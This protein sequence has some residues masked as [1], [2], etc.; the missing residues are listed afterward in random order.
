MAPRTDIF[1]LGRLALSSGEGRSL[2]LDVGIDPLQLAGQSYGTARAVHARLDVSRTMHGYALRLRYEVSLEGP[3]MRC[4]EEA[5]PAI[6]VDA[7]EI[8]QSGG[9]DELASP[10][11]DGDVLDLA[12]WAR[13]AFAVALPQQ[14]LC[15]DDCAGLC[16][17]CGEDLNAAAPGHG[18]ERA[19][20]PRWAKLGEL[21]FETG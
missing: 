2:D 11:V 12:A 5:A 16:H 13:D 10:Y 21:R 14:V 19:S 7:R 6:A 9:G 4:L 15:R 3:C 8:D 18:H 1:D 20:D 17:V